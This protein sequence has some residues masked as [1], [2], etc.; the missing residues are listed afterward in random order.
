MALIRARGTRYGL[1]NV[2]AAAIALLPLLA[3]DLLAR[4]RAGAGRRG[5]RLP[6]LLAGGAPLLHLRLPVPPRPAGDLY[7]R[8]DDAAPDRHGCHRSAAAPSAGGR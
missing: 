4:R 8:E 2:P 1:R 7:R 3:G 5:A 6:E